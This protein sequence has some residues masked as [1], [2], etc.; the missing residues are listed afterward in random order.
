[1]ATC[2]SDW[3][4]IDVGW[5][6]PAVDSDGTI[7]R[8]AKKAERQH[9]T[10]TPAGPV[11]ITK[12]DGATLTRDPYTSDQ[13]ADIHARGRRNQDILVVSNITRRIVAKAK[14]TDRGI[15]LEHWDTFKRRRTAWVHVYNSILHQADKQGIHIRA[16]NRAWTSLTCPECDFIDRVNRPDRGT[17]LCGHCGHTGQA[18]HIAAENMRLRALRHDRV[19]LDRPPLCAN[20]ACR[21]PDLY[22]S[23]RCLRCTFFKQRVGR[24]PTVE[25]IAQLQWAATYKEFNELNGIR[26]YAQNW[27][28]VVANPVAKPSPET[29]WTPAFA[30]SD[31][32]DNWA[33]IRDPIIQ[34]QSCA[35]CGH[36]PDEADFD[37]F[38][39]DYRPE[40]LRPVC[41]THRTPLPAIAWQIRNART[42]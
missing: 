20:P 15:A 4:G 10:I 23:G 24:Y 7:Y 16:V 22:R 21:S 42:R 28:M 33:Q 2:P 41:S 26:S 12:P 37:L 14:T 39:G 32:P 18:D 29:G 11:T 17:F 35:I 40:N 36:E 19:E 25:Q 8:W 13:L 6:Y 9:T 3:L 1:M 31:R 27:G 34:W 30:R 38:D 5:V